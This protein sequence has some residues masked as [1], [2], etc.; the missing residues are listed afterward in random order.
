M[1]L[2]MSN[3][4]ILCLC[5]CLCVCACESELLYAIILYIEIDHFHLSSAARFHI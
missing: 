2:I 1:S 5:L 4:C 3:T